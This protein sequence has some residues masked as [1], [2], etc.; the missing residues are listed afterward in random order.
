MSQTLGL[1]VN[2]VV[3]VNVA[4]QPQAAQQ[5]NFGSLLIV[6][7][8]GV[9]DVASR[10]RL[11][12]NLTDLGLDFGTSAPE[13]LAAQVFFS[14]NPQ[15]AQ[16]YVGAWAR[17]A[18]SGI[19]IGGELSAAQQQIANFNG[20]ANGG[21]NVTIDGSLQAL[22]GLNFTSVN[23]LNGVAALITSS[24][25]GAGVC[26]WDS[27]NEWFNIQSSSTGT[28]SSV[29]LASPPISSTDLSGLLGLTAAGG[30]AS[31]GG[32]AAETPLACMTI[33]MSMTTKWYG[34][35]FAASVQP[36][37]SDYIAVAG[38]VEGSSVSR[39]FGV[40]TQEANTLN[41][42]SNADV[43]SQ[44]QAL[45]Y[46][47]TFTQ[48]S[49]NTPYVC[50]ADFGIAFTVNFNGS[51]T[52]YTLK[53]QDEIGVVAEFLTETQA[54]TLGGVQGVGGKNCN[55]FVEYDDDTAILQQ[56][57]MASGQ[58]F[59]VIHGT[60]WLQNAIQ[61]AVYNRLKTARTKVPQTDSGVTSL[62]TTMTT[63][64]AQSVTNGLCAPGVWLGPDI[65][66]VVNGQTLPLGFLI[67]AAPIMSQ[68]QAARAA[69]Q[70]PIITILLKLA[71]AI[72]F[73]NVIMNVSV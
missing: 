55:V 39:I 67:F 16:V 34:A 56:G 15:P 36:Q 12:T 57:V 61:T 68:T 35:M 32:I 19:L 10:F 23:N 17:T 42:N 14:A 64:L 54:A 8:S 22:S 41:A 28:S 25:A 73:V 27:N 11:Y 48:Y 30:A 58:F 2:D 6:G 29:S 46:N 20:I 45:G 66:P 24:L 63:V 9:I 21:M 26:T 5:R 71:G 31:V 62:M 3:T 60:D 70:A 51:S 59:D 44:L 72:H 37:D 18:T 52:L 1:S 69:R 4:L 40:T 53:F 13:Y 50:A 43:A 49:S 7:D 33:L 65:G 47:R 38:L